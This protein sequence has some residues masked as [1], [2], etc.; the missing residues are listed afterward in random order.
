LNLCLTCRDIR[1]DAHGGLT[2]A[3]CDL[4]DALAEQGHSVHLLTDMV[5]S[6]A[7]V[8]ADPPGS[9][10]LVAPLTRLP[11][12]PG[13]RALGAAPAES[14]A[15]DLMY[16]AAAY[17]E[18]RR[19]HEDEEPVDAVLAPLWRSEGAVCLLDDRFPTIVS[20][21]TSM[22]TLSEVDPSS[23][24][25][26]EIQSRLSL[27]HESLVRSRYL[28][29]LTE[30]V[31]SKTIRDYRLSPDVTAVIG[32]GLRDRRGPELREPARDRAVRILFV[33]RLERRKGVDT[34]LAAANELLA[35]GLSVKFTL[36]GANGDPGVLAEFEQNAKNRA[37][38]REAV[39]LTGPVSDQELDDLYR[40]SDIVC[41]PS[42]YESH[43]VVLL[44]AMM[45]GKAIATCATGGIP[46]VVEAG[47]NALVSPPEDA[48]ALAESLRVLASD[49]RLCETLGAAA[50]HTYERRFDAQPVAQR[51]SAF[52]EAV[53]ASRSGHGEAGGG[54]V[55]T[56][57]EQLLADTGVAPP[58]S[59]RPAARELLDRLGPAAA[60]TRRLLHEAALTMPAPEVAVVTEGRSRVCAV[61]VTRDRPADLRRCLDSLK[62]AGAPVRTV[63]VDN[64]S[65]SSS[66][67]R[68]AAVCD[69]RRET[70][71]LRLERD[72]GRAR[73]RRLGAELADGEMV[74]LLDDDAEL[75]PGAIEHLVAELDAHPG[76]AAVSATVV[77]TDGRVQH[78]GGL[79]QSDEGIATFSLCGAGEPFDRARLSASGAA[80]W[81]PGTALLTRRDLLE[82]FPIDDR[83][84]ACYENEE[85][86]YRVG[87][88]RPG[89]F[90]R[91]REA[92]VIHHLEPKD[93]PGSGWDS[94][95]MMSGQ[96]AACARF[97]GRHGLLL[98]PA[99]FDLAPG[100]RLDDG[101]CD[102]AGARLLME[103]VSAKGPRWVTDALISGEL[104]GLIHA[105][106]WQTELELTQSRLDRLQGE[107]VAL[108]E[109]VRA[110]EQTMESLRRRREVTDF[111]QQRH[112]TLTA[113]EQ[114][115]WWRLRHR[116]LPA[117]HGVRRLSVRL[118]RE[119]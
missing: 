118:R 102:L 57:L 114:G 105:H 25:R 106:R 119:R 109:A 110:Q 62:L 42:R 89:V 28:H 104:S 21:M 36:A 88:E 34:L 84:G 46:E 9:G 13:P 22:Q 10:P 73:G 5:D 43:G 32:R 6:P 18:V 58:E 75:L 3:M 51:M 14:A 7:S 26:P 60:E 30:A 81:V 80:G 37:W 96:L 116:L 66:A 29:G 94:R 112:E 95:S 83:M 90:R 69:S 27:E 97:Y 65:G 78:S 35:G 76:A 115:G 86:C 56:R 107:T 71:L 40:D 4:A 48:I 55:V 2:R 50:R 53:I 47:H 12:G 85:W 82:R 16:A 74:L 67:N 24:G 100:L 44:E 68:I 101:T 91:S 111:L 1:S 63:V 64:G 15:R 70:Q 11:V 59:V 61:V 72:A 54:D 33:G 113:I 99:V 77:G 39:R 17:R 8:P 92:L 38:L 93:L 23:W 45:F 87:R 117:I 108:R 41:C 103:L 20:C 79:V 98:A 49:H 31:L 52:V 19:I